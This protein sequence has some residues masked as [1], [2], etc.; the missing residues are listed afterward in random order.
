VNHELFKFLSDNV[1]RNIDP[2]MYAKFK[3]ISDTLPSHL[4]PLCGA[5]FG[6]AINQNQITD[7]EPHIDKSNYHFGYNVVTGWGDFT[8]T[9]LLWQIEQ[10]IE[11]LPGDAIFFLGGFSHIML[12]LLPDVVILL[13]VFHIL[14]YFLGMKHKRRKVKNRKRRNMFKQETCLYR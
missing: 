11:I 3:S 13:I 9:L 10:S 1:L 4:K 12:F 7:G 14:L 8:S 2:R 5:W 6:C